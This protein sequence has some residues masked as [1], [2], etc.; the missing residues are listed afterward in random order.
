MDD[1]AAIAIGARL[2][3]LY[4]KVHSGPMRNMPVCN[5]A[6]E[7]EAIGFRAFSGKAVG[8]VVAPW[9]MN[10]VVADAVERAP[11]SAAPGAR[12]FMALPAGDVEFVSG[13]LDGF[14]LVHSCSLFSPMFEFADTMAA[15]AV[16]Q[17]SLAALFDPYLLAEPVTRQAAQVDRRALLR[18]RLAENKEAPP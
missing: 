9:F 6:I 16:A 5:D 17:A 14:G 4:A 8:V 11:T 10:L 18:G 15:R 12:S 1:E 3:E 13:W 2:V 7:V